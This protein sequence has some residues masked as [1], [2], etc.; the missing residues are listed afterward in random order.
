[1]YKNFDDC[2]NNFISVYT[3]IPPIT[4][5]TNHKTHTFPLNK[6]NIDYFK[7]LLMT[8]HFDIFMSEK[9]LGL[10]GLIYLKYIIYVYII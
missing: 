7:G 2:R 3:V 6:K 4:I 9:N 10:N 1:M 5:V 8:H